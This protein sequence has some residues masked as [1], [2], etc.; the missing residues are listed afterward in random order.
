[1]PYKAQKR[2]DGRKF[3]PEDFQHVY[4]NETLR[5]NQWRPSQPNNKATKEIC[6]KSY[7]GN[8]SITYIR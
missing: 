6:I 8:K 4:S 2:V 1:M 5:I 7:F 3:I